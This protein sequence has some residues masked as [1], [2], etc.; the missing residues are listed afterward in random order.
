M[1]SASAFAL[2]LGGSFF[3]FIYYIPIWFQAIK[4]V[5][6]TKSGIMNLPLILGLVI[7]SMVSGV[8]ISA[9]GYY[10]PAMYCSTILMAIGAGL[11]TTFKTT[12]GHSQWIGYQALY[13]FGV[14]FGMQQ[15][16]IAS[17]TVL[18]LVDVPMGTS[19]IVFTQILGGALFVSV[20]QNVFSNQLVAN[21]RTAVPNLNPAIVL[22]TGATSLKDAIP[23]Q[24]LHGTL[25][26]Y[27]KALTQTWYVGVALA[28]LSG[29]GAVGM[30]W[31]SVKEKKK[32]DA[33]LAE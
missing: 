27:N 8:A 32:V 7:T 30:E 5:S 29:I 19:V 21:L 15:P 10:T 16:L 13:G 25:I 33:T 23:H 2:C 22:E 1:A 14:G 9:V 20:A 4:G 24:Y 3:T 6:A 28:C 11:L 26:A 31:K 17:Q 18:P 12:T